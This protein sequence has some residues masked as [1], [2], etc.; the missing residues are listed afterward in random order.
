MKTAISIPDRVFVGAEDMA[1]N[2]GMTRSELYTIAI[3]EYLEKHDPDIVT[4]EL[5]RLYASEDSRL[6]KTLEQMQ[7]LPCPHRVTVRNGNG[8]GRDMVGRDT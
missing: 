7:F 5:N 6:D 1:S 3:R 4:E 8:T 2:R